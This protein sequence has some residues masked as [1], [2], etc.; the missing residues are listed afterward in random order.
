MLIPNAC[1]DYMS[2]TAFYWMLEMGVS[3]VVVSLPPIW[4]ALDS[5]IRLPSEYEDLEGDSN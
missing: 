3:V 2:I 4:T 1:I 5:R